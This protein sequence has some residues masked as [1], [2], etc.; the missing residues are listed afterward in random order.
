MGGF[1]QSVSLRANTKFPQ[2][3]RNSTSRPQQHTLTEFP[4]SRFQTHDGNTHVSLNFHHASLPCQ[5]QAGQSNSVSQ[6]LKINLSDREMT[7]R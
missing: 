5:F 3:R 4:A 1:V 6:L 2:K 7:D